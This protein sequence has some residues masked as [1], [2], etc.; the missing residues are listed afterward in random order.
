MKPLCLAVLLCV[1]LLV[2]AGC[3]PAATPPPAPPTAAS[4]TTA[5][6]TPVPPTPTLAPDLI[7]P[8]KAW[9]DG[10]NKGDLDAALAPFID[11][12]A[13]SGWYYQAG[14]K[15]DLRHVF[16]FLASI[17]T[18]IGAPE[19]QPGADRVA[20]TL[21]VMDGCMA[22]AGLPDGVTGKLEFVYGPDGKAKQ[23]SLDLAGDPRFQDYQKF[24]ASKDGWAMA[25]RPEEYAAAGNSVTA[26]SGAAWVKLCQEYA[27]SLKA[28]PTPAADLVA[29]VKAWAEALNK[30][31]V[32]AA[33]AFFSENA[34]W[35]GDDPSGTG[36]VELRAMFD[37]QSGLETKYQVTECKPLTDRVL[38]A[39]SET[40]GCIAASGAAEGLPM[41]LVLA[42][43]PGGKIVQASTVIGSAW[44]DFYEFTSAVGNWARTNRAEEFPKPYE[45]TFAGGSI[46]AKLC[47][48]YAESLKALPSASSPST[49]TADVKL[50]ILY[51]NTAIDPQLGSD[52]GFAALV[53]TGG[54]TVLFDTGANGP[55]LL[56]NMRQLNVK[57]ESIEAIIIS[58][59]HDD[60]TGGLQAL[61]DTGIRPVVYAPSEFSK[62]FK[63]QVRSRTELVEVTDPLTI[64]P[65][66][67][68]TRP[69][70]SIV[71][72][73]L[74]VETRDGTVVILG[75]AHPGLAEMVRQAQV[76][77]PG[78]VA[79][80]AGGFHL[81][82]IADKDSLQ[83]VITELRQ[84][85]VKR[86]LPTHCTGY[87]A[88][89]LFRAQF[90][91]SYL[92]GGVGRTVTSSVE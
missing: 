21:P 48:E 76:V 37:W 43:G 10:M 85:G 63:D 69:V 3:A 89:D 8:V 1:C 46:T 47:K 77:V 27:E 17:G 12:V 82:E 28:A 91:E 70:G 84:L 56:D 33:L 51:D 9:A 57:P 80:L 39:I 75:C 6:P 5:P 36:K 38:C 59:E 92:D 40:N 53:E 72:Q 81:L 87:A 55:M 79:L 62:A 54:H 22:A 88:T 66:V 19:C 29:P 31:D 61:L 71:E 65:G 23:G 60:H 49:A 42:F 26:E 25:N 35:I 73:G 34:T 15:A 7:A 68:L 2:V 90:G 16:D 78:K 30:G 64:V 24:R 41:E 74:A 44:D 52:W 50:T 58:H 32:E 11:D 4:P 18:R 67:H 45:T 83:S 14:G 86:V 20:C 13:W